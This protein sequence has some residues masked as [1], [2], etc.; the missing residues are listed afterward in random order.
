[1]TLLLTRGKG[2]WLSCML[3]VT[4]CASIL[5]VEKASCD[6]DFDR[7]CRGATDTSDGEVSTPAD[8]GGGEETGGQIDSGGQ[9]P[10]PVTKEQA[11]QAY[12]AD[13]TQAC[14]DFP[15]YLNESG[16]RVVCNNMLPLADADGG[17][18]EDTLECRAAVAKNA[19]SFND[20][21]QG[22]CQTA[23]PMGVGCG[24]ECEKYCD[25]MRRFCPEA[26]ED[27]ADTCV[28]DCREVPRKEAYVHT[29]TYD[30]T[31][32]CRFIHIQLSI[33]ESP[34]RPTH[35]RHAAGNAPCD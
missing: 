21:L 19:Q 20:D 14:T 30:N 1:M 27:M 31:L 35:C 18:L 3:T 28:D 13:I 7:E 12:C 5:G 23:G 22:D 29:T 32:E 34:N 25:Y 16:C 24:D 9:G 8:A 11:C 6:P 26:F 4:G 10:T 2:Y 33:V 17:L 15:Q